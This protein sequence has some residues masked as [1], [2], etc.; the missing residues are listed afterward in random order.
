MVGHTNLDER[1]AAD[2]DRARGKAFLRSVAARLRK[3]RSTEIEARVTQ[4]GPRT[5]GTQVSPD[6][7]SARR[8]AVRSSM[9]A[10]I[11]GGL[12]LFGTRGSGK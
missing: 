7:P 5:S 3:D 4:F 1:A 12:T 6:A 2:F 10:G 9:D 8:S 11:T